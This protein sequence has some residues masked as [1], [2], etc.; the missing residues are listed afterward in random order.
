M[1]MQESKLMQESNNTE[2]PGSKN[3][4]LIEQQLPPLSKP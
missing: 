1:S 4:P 2:I 3:I